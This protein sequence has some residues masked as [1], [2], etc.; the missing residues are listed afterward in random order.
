ME[1]EPKIVVLD[2]YTL[3]PGDLSWAPLEALGKLAVYERTSAAEAAGRALDADILVVNKVR[4]DAALLDR[5]PNLKC[6]CVLATGF[7]NIDTLSGIGIVLATGFNNIDT[8]KAK[9]R[10]IPVCNVK[11]YGSASVAQHVFA[12]M[13]AMVNGIADHNRSVQAGGWAAQPDFCYTL[14][15]VTELAGKTLGI[16]GLGQIGRQVARLGLAF[17]MEVIAVHKHPER[18]AMDGVAFV[19]LEALFSRS[20]FLTLHAPLTAENEGLV[21]TA[22]LSTMKPSARLINTSR[23]G[24]IREGDLKAALLSGKIAGAALDVLSAEPP[25]A[26]HILMG[27]DNCLITPHMAWASLEARR[28]LLEE[29]VENVKAFLAGNARNNVAV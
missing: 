17:D 11:G 12:M 5:L 18:D 26:D 13:L 6:V 8:G 14:F 27:V 28:R 1:K 2:G 21:N 10:D 25:P 4:L 7:N 19:D 15:P 23:G 3:N 16:Y 24:L 22:R 20:D 9:S 29:T